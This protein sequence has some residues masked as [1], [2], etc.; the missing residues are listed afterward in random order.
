MRTAMVTVTIA[1]IHFTRALVMFARPMVTVTIALVTVT[2]ALV[3]TV[4]C[5]RYFVLRPSQNYQSSGN[6]CQS[7][8]KCY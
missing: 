6:D 3:K 8:G 1:L 7:S 4:I 2:R 5:T